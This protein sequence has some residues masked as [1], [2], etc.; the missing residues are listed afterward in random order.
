[1]QGIPTSPAH[2]RLGWYTKK[3]VAKTPPETLNA[4]DGTICR[5]S[6][7]RFRDT[8]LEALVHCNWQ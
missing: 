5:V 7:D 2:D 4:G 6:P 1:V 8:A 3:V